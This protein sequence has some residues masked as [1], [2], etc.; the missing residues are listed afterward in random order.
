MSYK[1]VIDNTPKVNECK[2]IPP[3]EEFLDCK[4]ETRMEYSKNQSRS[5]C[6]NGVMM[7]VTSLI[8]KNTDYPMEGVVS[9][10]PTWAMTTMEQVLIDLN[11]LKST[12]GPSAAAKLNDMSGNPINLYP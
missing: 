1:N 10:P 11:S 5:L 8:D 7:I 4:C 6:F 12:S 3:Y 9:V 2:L